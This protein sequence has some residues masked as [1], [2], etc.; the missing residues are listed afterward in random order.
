MAR[1]K[2]NDRP[3]GKTVG[4]GLLTVGMYAGVFSYADT[5][6]AA[7]SQGSLWAAGPIATVFAV[8]WAHGSFAHNLWASMGITARDRKRPEVRTERRVDKR[9]RARLEA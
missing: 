4:Y 3:I 9:P 6:A 5:L 7:F 8:S 1:L 2:T